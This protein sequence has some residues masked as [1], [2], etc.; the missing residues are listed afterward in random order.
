MDCDI[1]EDTIIAE[2]DILNAKYGPHTDKPNLKDQTEKPRKGAHIMLRNMLNH[3]EHETQT[4]VAYTWYKRRFKY[5][6]NAVDFP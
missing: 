5:G 4:E 3:T 1:P 2:D 6:Y